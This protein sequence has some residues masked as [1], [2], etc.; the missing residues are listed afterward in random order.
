MSEQ[1]LTVLVEGYDEAKAR[2]ALHGNEQDNTE[3]WQ[4]IYAARQNGTI[5]QGELVGIES[6]EPER[7]YGIVQVGA[8]QGYI[9][10]QEA[11]EEIQHINQFRNLIGSKVVFKVTT[12]LR[13]KEQFVASRKTAL[14]QMQA[15]TWK[16]LSV[17]QEVLAIVRDVRMKKVK[18]EIGGITVN[19]PSEEYDYKFVNDLRDELKVGD[20]IRVKVTD[21]N[22]DDKKVKVSTKALKANM[23]DDIAKHLRVKGEYA[24]TITGVA[25]FGVFVNI[26]G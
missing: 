18:L 13:D 15:T 24:G 16:R 14:E 10:L 5:L 20:H 22:K 9:A 21:L 23:W 6:P 26:R 1:A 19:M 12:L 25:E 7:T 2:E 4:T 11:G 8:I 17:D 3:D